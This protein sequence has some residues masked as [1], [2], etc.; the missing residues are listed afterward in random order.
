MGVTL[1]LKATL[2]LRPKQTHTFA[3]GKPTLSPKVT[4]FPPEKRNHIP[5][6]SAILLRIQNAVFIIVFT[7]PIVEFRPKLTTALPNRVGLAQDTHS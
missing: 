3:Q 2:H 7:L 6:N 5:P 1:L 4:S